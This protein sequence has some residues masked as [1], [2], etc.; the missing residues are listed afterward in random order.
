MDTDIKA[1]L[2]AVVGVE[3][4]AEYGASFYPIVNILAGMAAR[5]EEQNI[6]HSAHLFRLLLG[7][8]MAVAN[9]VHKK[10]A[11]EWKPG[12]VM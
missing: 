7:S 11:D 8:A 5:G 6:V 10:A 3:F 9:E 12:W 1:K 4:L 2:S